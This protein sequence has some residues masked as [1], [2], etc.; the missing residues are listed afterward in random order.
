[1]NGAEPQGD[2]REAGLESWLLLA[3]L[4]LLP[5][6]QPLG[7]GLAGFWVPPC[8]FVFAAAALA[9]VVA[10]ARGRARLRPCPLYLPL[11]FYLGSMAASAVA[12][13][14]P[15]RSAIKLVGECYLVGL[16]VLTF[17]LVPSLA[18]AREG[19]RLNV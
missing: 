9:W 3:T 19:T 12:S 14:E 2:A 1:M 17:N 6:M 4:A 18:A 15:R 13:E 16:C 11:V 10:L 5:I 7:V 8:D